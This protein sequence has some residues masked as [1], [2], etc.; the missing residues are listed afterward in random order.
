MKIACLFVHLGYSKDWEKTEDYKVYTNNVEKLIKEYKGRKIFVYEQDKPIT[1]TK[2]IWLSQEG[3]GELISKDYFIQARN[4]G[5]NQ[6]LLAGEWVYWMGEACV[7]ILA[8]NLKKE[9]F[10]TNLIKECVYPLR[11]STNTSSFFDEI[12]ALPSIKKLY[13]NSVPLEQII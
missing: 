4:E 8:K 1:I 2:D 7:A 6:F 5:I 13:K 10:K 12:T 3:S 9:G 11:Y